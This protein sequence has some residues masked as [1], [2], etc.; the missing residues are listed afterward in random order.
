MVS[1][2][3]YLTRNEEITLGLIA[4]GSVAPKE[5]RPADVTRLRALGL[6]LG[7]IDG[8]L[9]VTKPGAERKSTP[10]RGAKC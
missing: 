9:A 4:A 7:T 1:F 8:E 10:R 6:V 5:L 3:A 2:R